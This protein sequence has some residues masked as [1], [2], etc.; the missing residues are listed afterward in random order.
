MIDGVLRPPVA[1]AYH[2]VGS[3]SDRVD[4]HRLVVSPSHLEAHLRFLLRRG[5]RFLT[6]SEIDPARRP[7][8]RTALL[9]FDDGFAGWVT[10]VLPLLRRLGLRATFYPCPGWWGG[11]HPLVSGDEARLLGEDGARALHE[12][13]MELGSHSLTHPDLRGLDDAELARELQGSKAAIEEVTGAACRTFAYP[14][15]LYDERV[16]AAVAEAGYSL[17]F[18]WLPGP[19]KALEAPR[20]PPP[21]RAGAWKLALKLPGAGGDRGLTLGRV[22]R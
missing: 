12:A 5:Y 18:A 15:G 11:S 1:L 19:W 20:L 17:A 16:V 10:H 9:T 7:A 22:R 3:A 13:G 21:P 14:Y 8:P 6:A 2:G 4:P